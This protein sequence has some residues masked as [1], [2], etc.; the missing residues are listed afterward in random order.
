MNE[1]YLAQSS[2]AD[3]ERQPSHFERQREGLGI[4]PE[5]RSKP[6]LY[7][8]SHRGVY[9]GGVRDHVEAF[10]DLMNGAGTI[11]MIDKESVSCDLT[12]T[13]PEQLLEYIKHH[14]LKTEPVIDGNALPAPDKM[15]EVPIGFL[16]N[17]TF[18]PPLDDEGNSL[19]G[20]SHTIAVDATNYESS[21]HELKTVLQQKG[22][23][24]QDTTPNMLTHDERGS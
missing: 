10:A 3:V 6:V 2:E 14:V 15:Q 12:S 4:S 23:L 7:L 24:R 18:L 8:S 5:L 17:I 13:S 22:V 11:E 1:Q 19:S 16:V 9:D 21:L 20:P